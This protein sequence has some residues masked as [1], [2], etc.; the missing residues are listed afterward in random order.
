MPRGLSSAGARMTLVRTMSN[1]AR[2][3][4][5]S[6]EEATTIDSA[7]KGNG[8]SMT[9]VIEGSGMLRTAEKKALLQVSRVL[10]RIV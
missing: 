8:E 3:S 2:T 9:S 7:V 6:A 10:A 5:V 1:G 4:A